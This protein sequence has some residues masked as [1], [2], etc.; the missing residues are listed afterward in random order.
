LLAAFGKRKNICYLERSDVGN[1]AV[2]FDCIAA[3]QNPTNG[4]FF[5]TK[6]A[7]IILENT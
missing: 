3:E 2:H 7:G 1:A 4:Q 6:L 5:A